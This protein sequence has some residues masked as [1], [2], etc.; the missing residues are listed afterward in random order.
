MCVAPAHVG[1]GRH[2]IRYARPAGRRAS[3]RAEA[4]AGSAEAKLERELIEDANRCNQPAFRQE[5]ELNGGKARL[6]MDRRPAPCLLGNAWQRRCRHRGRRRSGVDVE[7]GAP[8]RPSRRRSRAA[9]GT[10]PP[11]GRRPDRARPRAPGAAARAARAPPRLR[12]RSPRPAVTPRRIDLERDRGRPRS[13]AARRRRS[14]AG[15]ETTAVASASSSS[16]PIAASRSS[17]RR[18]VLGRKPPVLQ[19]AGAARPAIAGGGR[20]AA[21]PAVRLRRPR[22]RARAPPPPASSCDPRP[23]AMLGQAAVVDQ[24]HRSPAPSTHLDGGIARPRPAQSDDRRH[25]RRP[26]GP[27]SAARY[28]TGARTLRWPSLRRCRRRPQRQRR[29][30]QLDRRRR[31][32]PCASGRPC[33]ARRLDAFE[34]LGG[35]V[36]VLDE[37]RLHV[38][39]SLAQPLLAEGE[40]RAGLLDQLVLERRRRA[41]SP[42]RRCPRRRRCRTRPA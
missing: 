2:R 6:D 18:G 39:A 23:G 14:R 33:P 15:V 32:W 24:R 5:R 30:R 12:A 36:G 20:S 16:T 3:G 28:S 31:P 34:Q 4:R 7:A 35:D 19:A 27:G 10:S 38:R 11:A 25:D 37:E 22:R 9:P 13:A 29:R 41:R 42:P 26:L 8:W 17:T 40:V 1:G 21:A